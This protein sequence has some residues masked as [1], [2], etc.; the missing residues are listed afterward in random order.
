MTFRQKLV[1]GRPSFGMTL[2]GGTC[3][4]IELLG[5]WG[6]D[7][8]FLDTEHASVGVEAGLEKLVMSAKIGGVASIVRLSGVVPSQIS[9]TLDYG[10][11]GVV[12]PQVRDA[13]E[14][15]QAVSAAKYPPRGRR[16]GDASVRAAG[17]GGR[18]FNWTEYAA[19][20]NDASMVIPIAENVE[21]FEN[22]DEI[23][24]VPG[25]DIV[26]FGPNDYVLARGLP[27]GEPETDAEIERALD[28]L[29]D[30]AHVHG[31]AVMTL[32]VPATRERAEQLI[33]RGVDCLTTGTDTMLLNNAMRDISENILASYTT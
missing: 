21:F 2:Y 5:R 15:R 32:A 33:A 1:A 9:K 28:R 6:F 27:V 4:G 20:A 16:G 7:Y 24:S 30:R 12:I 19:R 10:A 22:I 8:A 31:V 18:G 13:E 25:V 14:M 26:A 11:D 17:F 29:I 23:L 3:I